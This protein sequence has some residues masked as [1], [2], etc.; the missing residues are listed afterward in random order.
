MCELGGVGTPASTHRHAS[1]FIQ[2]EITVSEGSAR[3]TACQIDVRTKRCFRSGK[4]SPKKQTQQTTHCASAA[5]SCAC[6]ISLVHGLYDL[7]GL[8]FA[9]HETQRWH[10][11]HALRTCNSVLPGCLCFSDGGQRPD[12]NGVDWETRRL[13]IGTSWQSSGPTFCKN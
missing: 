8:D 3:L 6:H 1:S 11:Q 4:G 5:L 10:P 9:C 12:L 13:T 2:C 7:S